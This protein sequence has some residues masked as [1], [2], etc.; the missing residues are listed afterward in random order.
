MILTMENKP[1]YIPESKKWKGLTVYCYRCGTNVS[2]IC[3]E[4]GQSIKLCK[5]G[6]KHVYKVY[7]S[8]PGTKNQRKTKKLETRDIHEAIKQAIEFEQDVKG[9]TH[10][11][12]ENREKKQV[13]KEEQIQTKP[14]LLI[15]AFARYIGWLHNEGVPAHLKKERSQDHIKDVERA[16]KSLAG[17]LKDNGYNLKALSVDGINDNMVGHVFSYLEKRKFSS[18]TFNKYFGYYTSFLKWY[19]E[20]YNYPIR[21]W[22]E[23]VKRKKLNPKPEAITHKEY[24]A[25]LKQISPENGIKEY[26]GVKPIR[27]VYR[28]WL[29]DG[30]RLALESG[31]RREEVINLKWNNIQESEGIQVIKV[32]DYK[33]NRIQNR[34]NNEEK[35]FIYIPITD[36]LRKILVEL[37]YEKH[38]NTDKFI[39]APDLK[40]NR[41]RVMADTLSRGFTHYYSQL[42]TGRKLTFKSLRKAYITNLEIYMGGGNTKAITGHTNDQVIE[43]NYIDKKEIAK[44]LR[45]FNVFSKESK[46]TDELKEIRTE[47]IHNKQQKN[48]EV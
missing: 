20:E 11:V 27:N 9:N 48:L 40:I 30:I 43:N 14:N 23:R 31:R 1:L 10:P 28:P 6:D 4:T 45:G 3:K 36:S 16:F 35:K 17:C 2:E 34:T 13:I 18:R 7:V 8:V 21:N 12:I 25:L 29:A 39:L 41:K 37:G 47:T 32:E 33:V 38:A 5:H 26:N 22:F 15:H 42:N 44:S 24:E 46:R 19:A